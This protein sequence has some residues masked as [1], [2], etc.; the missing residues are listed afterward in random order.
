MTQQCETLNRTREA[1]KR[2]S[3]PTQQVLCE[4]LPVCDGGVCYK[5]MGTAA[6]VEV[7]PSASSPS[8][9]EMFTQRMEATITGRRP[10]STRA[11]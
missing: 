9:I 4:F 3:L 2:K 7:H 1:A 6:I 10:V 5:A 11:S 8:R